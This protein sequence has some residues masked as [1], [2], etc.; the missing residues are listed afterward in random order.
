MIITVV[1]MATATIVVAA[2]EPTITAYQ[3]L[4]LIEGIRMAQCL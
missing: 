4:Y 2:A 3:L 1:V